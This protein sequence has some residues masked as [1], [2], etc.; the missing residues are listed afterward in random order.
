[1]RAVLQ[2]VSE[3]RVIVGGQTVGEIGHGLLV[4]LG[5]EQGDVEADARHLAD[6][7][8]GLRIF[9]GEEG[10]M[11]L[12]L[13]DTGGAVLAVSQFTLLADCRKGRRPGFSHA[14]PPEEARQLYQRFVDDLRERGL[15]VETG[16]F[17]A[18]MEVRLTNQGPVTLLLDSRK[19]F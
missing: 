8:E 9:E 6:K 11:N 7:T 17:Q 18:E 19:Q 14:A 3:A 2:R 4:L 12:S 15:H 5:V 10:K 16:T 1:M 13:S